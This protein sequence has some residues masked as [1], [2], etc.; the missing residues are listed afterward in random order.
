MSIL[1]TDS[2]ILIGITLA[3]STYLFFRGSSILILK[4][5]KFVTP[6]FQ[7][8]SGFHDV[9]VVIERNCLVHHGHFPV[10]GSVSQFCMLSRL[11][12]LESE[13]IEQLL[14]CNAAPLTLGVAT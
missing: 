11:N 10:L 9:L 5:R 1:Q 14:I 4:R 13:E 12:Q 7:G 6:P 8:K 2:M 3:R